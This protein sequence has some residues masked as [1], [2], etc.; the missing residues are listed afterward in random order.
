MATTKKTTSKRV[1]TPKE[2]D[3]IMNSF[4]TLRRKVYNLV[5]SGKLHPSVEKEL[6]GFIR[7]LDKAKMD[8]RWARATNFLRG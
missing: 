7:K 6:M 3:G 1:V 4:Y 2:F 5:E 8:T